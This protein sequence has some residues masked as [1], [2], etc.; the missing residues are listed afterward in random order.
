MSDGDEKAILPSRYSDTE[1]DA[2]APIGF[3]SSGVARVEAIAASINLRNRVCIFIGVFLVAFAYG[4]DA[5]LRFAYQPNATSDLNAHALLS[6][7]NVVKAV[8]AVV[9]QPGA[10]KVAD[11]FGR[12]EILCVSVA[13]Y[14]IGTIIEASC[15]SI[16][17]FALGAVMYQIGYTLVILI[18]EIIVADCT[19]LRSRVLFSYIPP[20]C[21]LI[22]PWFSPEISNTVL[23]LSTWRWGIGMWAIIYVICALPLFLALCWANRKAKQAGH[24]NQIKSPYQ[25]YGGWALIKVLFWQLDVIGLLLSTSVLGLTLTPLTLAG[26]KLPQAQWTEAKIIAPLAVGVVS[27]PIFVW[28]QTK[29]PF[30]LVPF[31]LLTDPTVYAALAIALLLNFTWACQADYLY[32]VL[33]IAF[34]ESIKSATRIVTLYSFVSVATGVLTGLII[35]RARRLKPFIMLGTCLFLVAFGLL[36]RYRGGPTDANHAGIIAA[37][38]ILGFGGGLFP[39]PAMASIQ[40]ATRHEHVAI[41]T[42]LYL[43]CYNFGSSLG[44]AVSGAIWTQVLPRELEKH[45]GNTTLAIEWYTSPFEKIPHHP[46]GTT[47]R[48]AIIEAFKHV[49]R[50]LCI[51]GAGLCVLLVFFSFVIQNPRLPDTQSMEDADGDAIEMTGVSDTPK[52]IGNESTRSWMF[53]KKQVG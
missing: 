43:S 42:G 2:G 7:I 32:S 33:I 31:H 26:G 52:V 44:N 46:V 16:S 21:Y 12:N 36:I 34:N 51:T 6:T 8:I 27:L 53:W 15:N 40:A 3:K 29:A 45:L 22:I 30:P 4:L 25:Q 24:L 41:V 47:E 18:L 13:F 39:Y 20:F 50:L 35:Y 1:R 9:V 5:V 17:T 49:Q 48:D 11:I 28:W 19:S 14:V 23:A 38:V 37:Q 10:A